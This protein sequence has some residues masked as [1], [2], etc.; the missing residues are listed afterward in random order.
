V[1]VQVGRGGAACV[2]VNV[3]PAATIVP[4]REL[5]PVLAATVNPTLPLPVPEVPAVMLIHDAL[6]VAVHAQLL[7]DAVTAIEPE[8]PASAKLCVAGD[9]EK[10]QA[11]GGAA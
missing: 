1:N 10:V 5:L 3:L 2:T 4:L 11:G 6:V 9:I 7:T 8:P